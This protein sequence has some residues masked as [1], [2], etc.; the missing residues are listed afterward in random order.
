MSD[1]YQAVYDATRSTLRNTDVGAAVAEAIRIEAGGLSHAIESARQEYLYAASAQQ[2][3][4]V[5]YR[6]AIS[7]DGN[8]WCALYGENLQDGVAGFGDSPALAMEA[9]DAAWF[10][11]LNP[12]KGKAV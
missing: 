5:L 6:P 7:I 2:R 3:P 8:Q 9:F 12:P 4:C 10:A 1:S 11:T